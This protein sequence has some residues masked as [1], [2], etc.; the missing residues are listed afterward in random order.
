MLYNC[1]SCSYWLLEI[2][3][4]NLEVLVRESKKLLNRMCEN[5]TQYRLSIKS[6]KSNFIIVKRKGNLNGDLLLNVET[7]EKV[8]NVKYLETNTEIDSN[9]CIEI[10]IRIKIPRSY[11][12]A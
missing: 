7:I 5:C 8:Q 3:N 4:N 11:Y 1:V 9:L 10:K 2:S 12:V 6:K